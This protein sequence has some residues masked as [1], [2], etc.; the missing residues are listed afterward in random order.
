MSNGD[1]QAEFLALFAPSEINKATIFLWQLLTEK[2]S[3]VQP[4]VS[5]VPALKRIETPGYFQEVPPGTGRWADSH[6]FK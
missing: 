6:L 2:S 3:G 1:F 5:S 4:W